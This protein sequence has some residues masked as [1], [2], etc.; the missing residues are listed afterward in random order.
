MAEFEKVIKG[1]EY[2][3]RDYDLYDDPCNGCP[4]YVEK[5]PSGICSGEL[6]KDC[7]DLLK[8]QK[9]EISNYA[10]L[11]SSIGEKSQTVKCRLGIVL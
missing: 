6:Q 4:Y 11:C 3:M 2:C 9:E 7:Y 8:E 10:V 1:L 5:Q